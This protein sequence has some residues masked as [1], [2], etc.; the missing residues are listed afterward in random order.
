[1]TFWQQLSDGLLMGSCYGLL[2]VGY[3]LLFGLMRLVNFAHGEFLMVGAYAGFWVCAVLGLP[4]WVALLFAGLVGGLLGVFT[5]RFCYAPLRAGGSGGNLLTSLGLSFLLQFLITL[6]FGSEILAYPALAKGGSLLGSSLPRMRMVLTAVCLA[7][8]LAISFAKFRPFVA[9]TAMAD[10]PLGA[11]ACGISK[12]KTMTLAFALSGVLAGLSGALWGSCFTLSSSM[13]T[14]LGLKAFTAAVLGGVGSVP[15]ACLGGVAL[16][17]LETFAAV[18][19]S[20]GAKNAISFLV[21]ILCL[22]FAPKH[23]KGGRS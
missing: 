18:W 5:W 11:A 7:A 19:V 14:N 12:Q 17:L 21:L 23:P 8:G 16:G 15:G 4:F 1:M 10:N 13:G 3:T 6:L 9:M 2:A 22:L 20:G